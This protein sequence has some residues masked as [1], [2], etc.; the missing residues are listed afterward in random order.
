MARSKY[1]SIKMTV[2]G[3]KF[4]SKK[5]AGAMIRRLFPEMTRWAGPGAWRIHWGGQWICW[6]PG[7]MYMKIKCFGHNWQWSKGMDRVPNVHYAD[8]Y[9]NELH[10]ML[11][12]VFFIVSFL[13]IG[14]FVLLRFLE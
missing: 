7:K 6:R 9:R 11:W 4:D 14:F 10:S 8:R 13:F 5:E 2:D 1:G 3:H 12:G